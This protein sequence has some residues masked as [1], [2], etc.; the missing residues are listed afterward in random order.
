MGP[1]SS[2]PLDPSPAELMEPTPEATHSAADT[3]RSLPLRTHQGHVRGRGRHIRR[4]RLQQAYQARQRHRIP[5]STLVVSL[6]KTLDIRNSG[7]WGRD[8]LTNFALLTGHQGELDDVFVEVSHMLDG[9][10]SAVLPSGTKALSVQDFSS[11]V[12]RTGVLP[13]TKAELRRTIRFGAAPVRQGPLERYGPGSWR[14]V[15]HMNIF[16]AAARWKERV[17]WHRAS[18]PWTLIPHR[19]CTD[20]DCPLKTHAHLF[21]RVGET[22][23]DSC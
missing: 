15:N 8:E 2:A 4:S 6:F 9:F 21:R 12:A 1:G 23:G 13:L 10:A 7:L 17:P 3:E 14:S 5:K 20:P 22:W 19:Q 18:S 11:I 16:I